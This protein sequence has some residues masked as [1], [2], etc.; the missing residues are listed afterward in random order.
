MGSLSVWGNIRGFTVTEYVWSRDSGIFRRWWAKVVSPY[1]DSK[2]DS[3]P[4]TVDS[5]D[6]PISIEEGDRILATSLLPPPPME[7]CASSTISQRLVEAFQTNMEATTPVLEYLK[8][9]TLVFSKQTFNVL[10]SVSHSQLCL[11]LRPSSDVAA[12]T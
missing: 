8:E 11:C 4:D 3:E 7:I 2:D 5:E 6:E 9:F 10:H 1:N 12:G